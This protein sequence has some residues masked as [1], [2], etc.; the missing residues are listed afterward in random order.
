MI[1]PSYTKSTSLFSNA[2]NEEKAWLAGFIDGEGYIGILKQKKKETRQQA[3][4]LVYHPYLIVTG[5]N[6]ASIDCVHSLT[7]CGWVVTTYR[8]DH[9]KT[10]YQY[11]LSNKKLE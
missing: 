1:I 5:T 4:S 2:S 6:K 8:K 7:G 3:A 10:A 9:H 11:K